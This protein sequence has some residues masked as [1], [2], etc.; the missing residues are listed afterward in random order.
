METIRA[1]IAIPLPAALLA[2]LAALQRRLERK[3]PSR[4]VR[5]RSRETPAAPLRRF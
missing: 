1:F 4:S 2:E 3:V 5:C